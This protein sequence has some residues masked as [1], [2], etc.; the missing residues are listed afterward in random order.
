MNCKFRFFF[1]SFQ[2]AHNLY[3]STA[4]YPRV[5][6]VAKPHHRFPYTLSQS[7]M[8]RRDLF[9]A[10]VWTLGLLSEH[11]FVVWAPVC[12]PQH[13]I[14][15]TSPQQP[16][17]CWYCG[18]N[19]AIKG[20]KLLGPIKDLLHFVSVPHVG[21]QLSWVRLGDGS[22]IHDI[23]S[24]AMQTSEVGRKLV[25]RNIWSWALYSKRYRK[26]WNIQWHIFSCWKGKN[27]MTTEKN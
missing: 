24:T 5:L 1:R 16:R 4:R 20:A 6:S 27:N 14:K 22:T 7:P 11:R 15:S 18:R 9:F 8:L 10:H 3:L 12:C 26:I 2:K 19:V 23:H 17:H 21:Y 25:S 13:E